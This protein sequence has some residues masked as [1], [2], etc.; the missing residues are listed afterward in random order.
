MR[1]LSRASL[2]F[3]GS[4]THEPRDNEGASTGGSQPRRIPLYCVLETRSSF[5]VAAR[6]VNGALRG[7]RPSAG[8]P[9]L[10]EFDSRLDNAQG[11]QSVESDRSDL[12][13]P[14]KRRQRASRHVPSEREGGDR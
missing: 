6:R 8:H 14:E 11:W 9:Q 3:G 2:A 4:M 10:L 13:T 12:G 7:G 1:D 5:D